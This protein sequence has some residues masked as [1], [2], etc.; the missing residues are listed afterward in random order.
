MSISE[1]LKELG[2]G[3]NIIF[4]PIFS[5]FFIV[6]S[7]PLDFGPSSGKRAIIISASLAIFVFL[8]NPAALPCLS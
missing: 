4:L 3:T 8:T 2:E 7:V 6:S 5:A 1:S